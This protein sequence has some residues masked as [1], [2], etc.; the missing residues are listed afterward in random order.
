MKTFKANQELILFTLPLDA[1]YVKPV[2]CMG[3][4][5]I[6]W[7]ER[8][9]SHYNFIFMPSVSPNKLSD[10]QLLGK[11]SEISEDVAK[12][13]VDDCPYF[14]K[15]WKNYG[16]VKTHES[17]KERTRDTSC[18]TAIESLQS[19]AKHLGFELT[20]NIYLLTNQ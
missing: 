10:W 8:K 4:A 13:M 9:P 16:Y 2:L 6:T 11:L 19:I 3:C 12:T 18:N 17:V 1:H 15:C 20:D 5:G 14:A 7:L